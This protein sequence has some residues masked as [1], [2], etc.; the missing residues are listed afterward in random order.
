M[1]PSLDR[2]MGE[3]LR[4]DWS[5]PLLNNGSKTTPNLRAIKPRPQFRDFATTENKRRRGVFSSKNDRNASLT[6]KLQLFKRLKTSQ[7]HN[8]DRSLHIHKLIYDL[9]FQ[10]TMK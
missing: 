6:E 3:I 4:S 1:A 10:D 5:I 2:Q 7:K 8:L 9:Y